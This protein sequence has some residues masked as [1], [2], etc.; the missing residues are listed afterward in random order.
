MYNNNIFNPLVSIVI[1]VYNAEKYIERA[2]KSLINQSYKNIEVIVVNDGSTDNTEKIVKKYVDKI[3]YFYKENGGVASA[4]NLGI[5]NMKGEYFSWLSHD[6]VYYTNKIERQIEELKNILPLINKPIDIHLMV[7]NPLPYIKAINNPNVKYITI[8]IE[9]DKDIDNL[10]DKIHSLGYQARLAISPN[11]N[12]E[13]L[14]PYLNKVEGILIMSVNPGKGGQE[15]MPNTL[16]RAE[17]IKN[18]N[19]NLSLEI[20]GGVN[21]T[22]VDLIKDSGIDTIVVGSYI[23]KSDDYLNRINNL[24]SV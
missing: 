16:S 3:R 10:I 12:V 21:N 24:I 22:N 5:K 9:I 6:D 18:I 20:D 19:N 13:L 23:T 2:L 15:F 1:P 7:E 4:L 8:H 17:Y 11:T 14:Y